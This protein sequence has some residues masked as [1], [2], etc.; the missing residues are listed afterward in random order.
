LPHGEEAIIASGSELLFVD[1]ALDVKR[2]VRMEHMIADMTLINSAT[3]AVCGP[4]HIALVNLVQGVFTKLV[5]SA[6][7]ETYTGVIGIG[8]D[9]LCVSTETGKLI[10]IDINSAVELGTL[11]LGFPVRGLLRSGPHRLL[12]FGGTWKGR[13]KHLSVVTWKEHELPMIEEVGP[14]VGA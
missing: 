12:A 4:G 11:D 2:R 6:G 5:I 1:E 13:G 7:D 8:D 14:A 10:A 3:L 9:C